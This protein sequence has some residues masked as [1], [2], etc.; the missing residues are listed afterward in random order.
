MTELSPVIDTPDTNS[1]VL[2]AEIDGVKSGGGKVAPEPVPEKPEP[3]RKSESVRDSLEAEAKKLAA[4]PDKG[5]DD[6]SEPAP[7][8][9]KKA[10]P[11]V[12]EKESEAK[13]KDESGQ[14][15]KTPKPS[16]GRKIIEAPARLLPQNRE[17][18]KG[19][20][21]PI[22]EE[23]V[24]REQEYEREISQ[25]RESHQFREELK[26]FDDLAKSTGTTV[27]E[28]LSNYVTMEKA[29]RQDPA[30]GL[31]Q[32]FQNL[33]M[34]P[35][36]AIGAILQ[37]AGVTPQQLIEHM[38]REPHRYNPMASH[39]VPQMQVQ[40]QAQAQPAPDPE[41]SGLKQQL[42]QMQAQQ[43]H[44]TVIAPFFQDF[45]EAQDA[46]P[47]IEEILLSG[48]VEKIH[49]SSLSPRDKLEAALR[50]VNPNAGAQRGESVRQAQADNDTP[51]G[52]LRGDR[53]IKSSPGAVTEVSEPHRKMSMRDMLEEEARKLSRRA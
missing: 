21:H 17:L 12:E 38:Q 16:E 35:P 52:D 24:R 6:D 53:S 31:K 30:T 3:A 22:R 43:V 37:S 34:D 2:D 9:E 1:T 32:L 20:A 49:G 26:E 13:A 4:E 42:A 39:N 50:M 44:A 48:I 47:A 19:V 23:W 11:A 29:I 40:Q 14:E 45:P 15:A 5:E 10:P 36:R 41:I 51:A 27:K 7:K 33:Q 8:A 18:W 46:W 25:Y 28:A